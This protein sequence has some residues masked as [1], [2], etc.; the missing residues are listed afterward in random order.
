MTE[1]QNASDAQQ[2]A[3]PE[4]AD[5]GKSELDSLLKEFDEKKPDVAKADVFRDLAP[6]AEYAKAQMEK[7]QRDALKV[8]VDAAIGFMK[9]PEE[10]KE[11]PTKLVR[12]FL[13]DRAS[14][15]PSFET[16]FNERGKNPAAWNSA[17]EKAREDFVTEVKTLPINQV[18]TEVEAAKAT[19][20]GSSTELASIDGPSVA[21]KIKMSDQRWKAYLDDKEVEAEQ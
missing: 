10:L 8:D 5:S 4:S 12:G 9:E 7:E 15:D 14:E 1:E 2:Q 21:E 19:V 17:L 11:F 16:A 20:Q 3:G 6:V 18:R 13:V